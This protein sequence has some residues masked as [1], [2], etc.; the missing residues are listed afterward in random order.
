MTAL[1][2]A[3]LAVPLGLLALVWVEGAVRQREAARSST[4]NIKIQ[5]E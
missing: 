5:G 3:A 2:L 1:L 4:W